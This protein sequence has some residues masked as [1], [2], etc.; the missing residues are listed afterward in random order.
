[1][2]APYTRRQSPRPEISE[3]TTVAIVV[4]DLGTLAKTK[5]RPHKGVSHR[6]HSAPAGYAAGPM[7]DNGVS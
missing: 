3:E 1:M 4:L 2:P 6:V 7:A 5:D